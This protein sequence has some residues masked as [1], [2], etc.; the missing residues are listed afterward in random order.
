MTRV[1]QVN[2]EGEATVLYQRQV[3][4][5][6]VMSETQADLVTHALQGV[7]SDGGTGEGAALDRPAAGKTGTSQ[8]NRNAWF[9]GYVP[10]MTAVVWM[11]YP[12]ATY[13]GEDDPDTPAVEKT[14]WPMNERR[15]ARPRP[16]G[17][18]RVVPGRR[19]GTT[20]WRLPRP[21]SPAT[22]SR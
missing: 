8:N 20:S 22:S 7:V 6:V 11:G 5:D 17:D 3:Q 12:D 14:L 4:E 21:T 15:P 10:G 19:S 1:E 18:R 9:A 16:P 2:E 13:E